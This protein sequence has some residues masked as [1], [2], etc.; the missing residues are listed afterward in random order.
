MQNIRWPIGLV[1]CSPIL[2]LLW[3]PGA[4][5]ATCGDIVTPQLSGDPV[6]EPITNCTDPFGVTADPQSQY[7]AVLD[8]TPL[9]NGGSFTIET[10]PATTLFAE[11]VSNQDAM[12]LEA[13][14]YRHEGDDLLLQP[15]ALDLPFS[16]GQ[17]RDGTLSLT[18]TGTYTLVA[19][20]TVAGESGPTAP[21]PGSPPGPSPN[22][23]PEPT[24]ELEPEADPASTT[25]PVWLRELREFLLPPRAFAQ[26]IFVPLTEETYAFTFTIA[27]ATPPPPESEPT[28]ASNVLFL[29][30]IQASRLHSAEAVSTGVLRGYSA[31]E[32][33]WEPEQ[34]DDARMLQMTPSG[35]SVRNIYAPSIIDTVTFDRVPFVSFDVLDVYANFSDF[36]DGLVRSDTINRWHP[37]AYDWR[38]D[39]FD[40]VENGTQRTA[41]G[42]REDIVAVVEALAASSKTGQVTIVGHSNGGLLAKALILELQAQN[43]ADLID[44]VTFV[45]VPQTGTPQ[46]LGT[47]LHGYNQSQGN[48]FVLRRSVAREVMRNFPGVYSLFPTTAYGGAHDNPLITFDDSAQSRKYREFYGAAVDTEQ[49]YLEFLTGAETADDSRDIT[50]P[51]HI[52]ST[53][54]EVL[55]DNAMAQHHEKLE[56]WSAP[57]HIRV[58]ELVGIGLPTPSALQYASILEPACQSAPTAVSVGCLTNTEPRPFLEFSL[59]GDETVMGRSAGAYRGAKELYYFDLA[60][61][62]LE[63]KNNNKSAIN[64]GNFMELDALHFLFAQTL[65]S[66]STVT[67]LPEHVSVDLFDFT[68]EYSVERIASPVYPA[69]EDPAG[70]ITGVVPAGDGWEVRNEIPGSQYLVFGGVKYLLLP[71][72]I[73][74]ITTLRGYAEGTYTYTYDILGADGMQRHHTIYQASTTP[75]MVA[76]YTI[77]DGERSNLMVDRNGDGEIDG[78]LNWDGEFI[79][80][81]T[82]STSASSTP[83]T[84]PLEPPASGSIGDSGEGY[85]DSSTQATRVRRPT[86]QVAGVATSSWSVQPAHLAELAAALNAL[87]EILIY[88]EQ[89]YAR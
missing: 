79:V 16:P 68:D 53:A 29:P 46:A 82:A 32:R 5:W 17:S 61:I 42:S 19:K 58:V 35:S 33:L 26:Q 78:Q 37:Y 50:E 84:P 10:V 3:L 49:E 85:D 14:L 76:R 74:R 59:L 36:L 20:T 1:G 89:R 86:P 88:I 24:P 18:A 7:Q 45:G 25:Q 31:G 9:L 15:D 47:I 13:A 22:L 77:R 8:D 63:R 66:S 48:G 65:L 41:D 44:A 52:P 51:I 75:Q 87:H 83:E 4:A 2:L 23:V 64:H 12:L 70:N 6:R 39:V 11:S 55:L 28:G 71:R 27:L 73:D 54:N 80:S 56:G 34:N 81:S 69:A 57:D 38:Y 67:E 21:G 40:I 60:S 72:E 62:S 30:G 43:K